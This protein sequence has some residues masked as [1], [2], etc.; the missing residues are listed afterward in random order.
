VVR[1]RLALLI[2]SLAASPVLAAQSPAP[3]PFGTLREQA[4]LQQAWLRLRL[5]RHVPMLLREHGVGCWVVPMR[6]YNED[7]VFRAIVAPTTFAA[8][9]RT[10]Y[11]F[12]DRGPAGVER[13]V[14]GG[15]GEGGLYRSV[16]ATTVASDGR[17]GEWWGDAQWLALRD[18]LAERD[19]QVIAVNRSR[20]FALAD[21]LSSGE[22]EAMQAALGEPWVS[23]IRSVDALPVD[24][25]ALRLPEEEAVYRQLQ[26]LVWQLTQRM[27]SS[28][29]ITPGVTR[30][31]DLVWWWRE[32]V[33]RLGLQ[34]WFQPSI[35][36]QRD[37]PTGVGLEPDPIIM[38]GDL[39]WCDV[40]LVALGL[41][42]DTQHNAYVLKPGESAA[43]AGL[44]SALTRSNRLQDLLFEEI[45]PG[46]TGNEV[47]AAT[48]A[49]MEAEGLNGTIYTHPIGLHGHGAGSTIGLWD[50]QEGV[51]GRGDH[52][53]RTG[54]WYSSE[55]QVSSAVP[56]WGNQRVRMAQE[57]DF[58]LGADGVP[59]W[60]HRRQSQLF[61]VR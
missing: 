53:I 43:P 25:I 23:R 13:L 9:R 42:T 39:L 37:D 15:S 4:Q 20:T 59:R 8:R 32:E 31:S 22:W 55:L 58:L 10:I 41:H 54:T 24:L 1:R 51:P 47:L 26:Q 38:P 14:I 5:D 49:R 30:T 56:E 17:G 12:C 52:P 7:P 40:G 45:R 36:V 44:Q 2:V 33:R 61:L 28:E 29:V 50:H 34:T 19:P 6:E 3:M 46:R 21:G 11:V 16:T 60:F 35:S 18:L 57:E 48:R 27:F